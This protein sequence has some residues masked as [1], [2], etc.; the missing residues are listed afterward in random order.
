MG[1]PTS[2]LC[3]VLLTVDLLFFTANLTKL[4][5]GAWLLLL[6]GIAVFTVLTTWQKGRELVTRQRQH[7][8][9]A[10]QAFIDKLHAIKPPLHRVPGT[11]IFFNRGKA[12][13]PL[14][15]RANVEHDQMQPPDRATIVGGGV[16]REWAY[17]AVW[18]TCG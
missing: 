14:V 7:D 3:A 10:L 4:V 16:P 6:I 11:A 18:L 1:W 9:G 17:L 5:H 2:S 12:T 8:E 13:A 15:L